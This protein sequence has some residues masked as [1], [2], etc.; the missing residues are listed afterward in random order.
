MSLWHLPCE[1]I[2]T[3]K[4]LVKSAPELGDMITGNGMIDTKQVVAE[5]LS[6]CQKCRQEYFKTQTGTDV[7]FL[8]TGD[9]VVWLFQT[10]V[11]VSKLKE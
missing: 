4:S 3:L 6:Q 2:C 1:T 10:I 11:K 8:V 9:S 5:C 7:M